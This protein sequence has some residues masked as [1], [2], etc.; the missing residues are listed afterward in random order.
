MRREDV[1]VALAAL[2]ETIRRHPD[3]FDAYVARGRAA[4]GEG[5]FKQA[6]ADF[7]KAITLAPANALAYAYRGH[8][9]RDKGERVLAF[10][11]FDEA[12]RLEPRCAEAYAG[13]GL[14]HI[15]AGNRSRAVADLSRV[16]ELEGGPNPLVRSIAIEWFAAG[17]FAAAAQLLRISDEDHDPYPI[18]YRFVARARAGE[19]AL[20]E[21]A[22]HAEQV[23]STNWPYPLIELF[24]RRRSPEKVMA[25]AARHPQ[26]AVEAHFFIAQWHLI[27]CKARAARI[28]LKAALANCPKTLPEYKI[29]RAELK[30]LR[31]R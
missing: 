3:S 11:D 24:L 4:H 28:E 22:A 9:R 10:A 20:A 12:I 29:A 21:L 14:T 1:L 25:V 16:L 7:D 8:V 2:D 19:N 23:R 31:F 15:A 27:D 17:D 30:R 26:A 5:L 18:L 6:I 13:R